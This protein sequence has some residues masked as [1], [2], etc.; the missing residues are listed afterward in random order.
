MHLSLATLLFPL[1]IPI[2]RAATRTSPPAGSVV[3]DPSTTTSGQFKTLSSAVASL[4]NDGSAQ[5]IFIFPGTYQEQVLIDRSGAVTV[6]Y[7]I[8]KNNFVWSNLASQIYGYTT[9]TMDFTVNQVVI[10]HNASLATSS[11]DDA[12]GTL[13]I[14]SD[15]VRLYNLDIRNDFGV[16]LTNGQAIAL[17]EY[18]SKFGAYACRFFSYQVS[19][20]ENYPAFG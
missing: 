7:S 5:T 20:Y 3:V 12:T 19:K 6:R 15:N 18:G 13:R 1:L 9:D 10:T 8:P 17:S 16:A 14:K 11:S 4:P 2:V